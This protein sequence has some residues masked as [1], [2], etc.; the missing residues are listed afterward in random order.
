MKWI[1][2]LSM[3]IS[4]VKF[5][6]T[7][8]VYTISSRPLWHQ[9]LVLRKIIFPWNGGRCWFRDDSSAL[10]LLCTLF[11]LLLHQLHLRL[12]GI[13]SQYL[14]IPSLYFHLW[15]I[16]LPEHFWIFKLLNYNEILHKTILEIMQHKIITYIHVYMYVFNYIVVCLYI[17]GIFLPSKS[18][19]ITNTHTHTH[20]HTHVSAIEYFIVLMSISN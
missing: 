1:V 14:G 11:L 20:T 3:E 13:R 5:F 7:D 6:Q 9:G 15:F 19:K 16:N 8:I 17:Y 18:Y 4:V 2:H 12:S 10:H